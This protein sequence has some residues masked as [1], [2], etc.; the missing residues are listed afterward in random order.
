MGHVFTEIE[1]SHPRQPEL[2]PVKVTTL[3]DTGA[4]LL[5][6]PEHTETDEPEGSTLCKACGLCC[7]GHFFTQASLRPAEITTAQNLGLTVLQFNDPKEPGFSLPCPLWQDQCT[8]YAHPQKPHVCKAFQCKLLKEIQ[9]GETALAS[10]LTV[11]RQAKEMIH[12]LRALLPDRPGVSFRERLLE[13]VKE[14]KQ[15]ATSTESGVAFRLKAG[16]LLIYFEQRF[17]VTGFFNK[18]EEKAP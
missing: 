8:I 12:E 10:A 15:S 5:C 17:G 7:T 11:V 18:P 6:L 2:S 9:D 13:Y 14:L 1:L 3:A 16:V 4:L